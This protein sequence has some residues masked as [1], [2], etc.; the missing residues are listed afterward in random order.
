LFEYEQFAWRVAT[1]RNSTTT[2]ALRIP[3]RLVE[4]ET[5]YSDT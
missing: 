4:H 2:V 3:C 5:R 1:I